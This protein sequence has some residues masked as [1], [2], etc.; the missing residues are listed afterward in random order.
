M[1]EVAA[2]FPL[3]RALAYGARAAGRRRRTLLL[4]IVTVA[5]GALLLV[6]VIALLPAV[7]DQGRAFGNEG[8]V[9]RA[10]IAIAVIVLLVGALEVVIAATRSIAQRAAE[11]GV[12][13]TFGVSPRAVIAALL[14]EPLATGAIGSTVGAVLGAAAA[15]I[16]TAAGWIDATVSAAAVA[17]GVAVAVGVAVA[18]AGLASAVPTW[19]A[20]HRPPLASL[21]T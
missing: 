13:C 14:V 20:V 11:I 10:A 3:G 18:T 9:G 17:A 5:T 1:S 15:Y 8:E 2:S 7:Q 6:L 19:R 4:P 16:G 21:T 12:L